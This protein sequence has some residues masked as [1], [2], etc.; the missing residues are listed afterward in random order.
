MA[1][2]W[3]AAAWQGQRVQHLRD[4]DRFYRWIIAAST[5]S[6]LLLELTEQIS[7]DPTKPKMMDRDLFQAITDIAETEL[8]D[9]PL[10]EDVPAQSAEESKIIRTVKYVPNSPA[11]WALAQSDV[12]ARQ[13]A[14]FLTYWREKR[15]ASVGSQ[16]DVDVMYAS[17]ST[18]ASLANL[19]FGFRKMAANLLWLEVD[20]YWHA[21]MLHR[22]VPLMN[23]TV[24][25]DP[26]FVD[27][28]LIG[29]WHLAY[30]A[31]APLPDTPEKDKKYDSD[32]D[33]Y[34][35]LKE[36]YY[37][38]AVD[39][40]KDGIRK[41][42]SDYRLYFDL[43]FGV[44]SEKL[45]DYANAVRYLKYAVQYL[46]H[47]IWVPRT[48]YIAYQRNGQHQEAIDGWKRYLERNPT[49]VNAPRFIQ[50]NEAFLA[51]K[52]MRASLKEKENAHEALL[53][54]QQQDTDPA[55]L[56]EAQAAYD[57]IE[58]DYE[59]KAAATYAKWRAVLEAPG[60]SDDPLAI[61]HLRML[62]AQTLEE[63][64][65]SYE[66]IAVLT[67][68]RTESSEVFLE[69]SD[70]IIEIKK[71]AHIPLNASEKMELERREEANRIRA[72]RARQKDQ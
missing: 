63:K 4:S 70:R 37:Y 28:Y 40:L 50:Y 17:E 8:P 42:P 71:K 60:G 62:E 14:D 72:E 61:A 39:F 25:L 32:R 3:A 35:G 1:V 52:T 67:Q 41:N 44:Y 10:P 15:L 58:K 68:A 51:E 66:A 22:M 11:L 49:N 46:K 21:G 12:L 13:R 64:G 27:A 18:T 47:D 43:G 57:A 33:V 65:Q 31:T 20:K 69:A 38:Q 29:A 2:V 54:A 9:V 6:S 53:L 26:N 19:F 36:S 56:S 5:Q 23:L 55:A 7:N 34:L 59:A 24:T 30:N 16:L 48:L 45:K